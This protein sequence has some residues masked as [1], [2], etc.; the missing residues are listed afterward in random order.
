MAVDCAPVADDFPPRGGKKSPRSRCHL[1]AQCRRAY[2][3]RH[4]APA[5]LSQKLTQPLPIKDGVVLLFAVW[6]WA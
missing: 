5:Y 4:V 6:G 3:L 1:L 2:L